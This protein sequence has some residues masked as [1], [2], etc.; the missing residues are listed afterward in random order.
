MTRNRLLTIA[1]LAVAALPVA[2]QKVAL[3]I[4]PVYDGGGDDFAPAVTQ[5]LTLY[6]Y[7]Q[8]I[9]SKQFAPVLLNPGGIY[10]PLDTSW[11]IEYSQNR[12][13]GPELDLI[14]VPTLKHLDR[15]E[16]RKG[17]LVVEVT[18]LDARSGDTKATWN[19]NA[20][21]DTKFSWITRPLDSL[22]TSIVNLGVMPTVTFEREP[23]GKATAHLA[24]QIRD[25]LPTHLA[26]L[27][28]ATSATPPPPPVEP[29]CTM[30]T[31]ITYHYK[32]SASQSYL[33][34]VNHLDQSANVKDGYTTFHMDSGPMVVQ[35]AVND[36]P[37]KLLKEPIYQLS[38]YFSCSKSTLIID[39]GPGG[40]AHHHWE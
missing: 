21:I 17:T 38:T 1:L 33:L 16:H 23:I 29:S 26:G 18:L 12:G 9:D 40:D 19:V 30:H 27:Q 11:L 20:E 10:S 8:F 13:D 36:A 39:L 2:A 35:F 31:R 25:T 24:E 3:G 5:F 7:E 28:V 4:A 6:M 34:M 15:I 37:Y 14:L 32:H 22:G